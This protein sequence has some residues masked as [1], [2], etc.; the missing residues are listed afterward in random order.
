MF[1]YTICLLAALVVL[2][3]CASPDPVPP[4]PTQTPA[5]AV[6]TADS[7]RVEAI[8]PP[9]ESYVD[10]EILPG[11]SLITYQSEGG[12]Y[13]APLDPAT[14]RLES[15]GILV[16]TGAARLLATF[17]GPEFGIDAHG[18]A[19]YY[20]KPHAGEVQ[21]WRATLDDSGQPQAEP[22]TAGSRFQTQLVSRNPDADTT[23]IA[24]IEGTWQQ[25]TAVWFDEAEPDV[26]Y[27]IDSI[28]NGVIPLR[29]VDGSSLITLSERTGPARGQLSLLDTDTNT[30]WQI[31]DDDG[32]KTDPYGW[33]APEFGGDLLV[34]AIVDNE[35]VAIYRDT[36]GAMW[37]RIA[38]LTPPPEARFDFVA[39]AEPFTVGGR[40]YLS[41]VVKDANSSRQAFSDSEVWLFDI[42]DDPQGRYAERGDSGEPGIA[43]SDPEVFIGTGHVFVYYNVIGGDNAA[44]PYAVRRCR[45]GIM[46]DGTAQQ[47]PSMPPDAQPPA[48]SDACQWI[49]P[50]EADAAVSTAFDPHYV[51]HDPDAAATDG[52]LVFL[53]GT[54]AAPA[55][56]ELFVQEAAAVG[57]HA[58]GLSYVNPRSVNLQICPDDTDPDCHAD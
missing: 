9:G 12:I 35:S 11:G 51:C 53:P 7:D 23:H 16:D 10:P 47:P 31:T 29:W 21:I 20:A 49:D 44:E 33:F 18:W 14:G 2:A 50:A 38:T 24:A 42:N 52:L 4:S 19:L 27:P 30:T 17:N 55:D 25:G 5:A 54:G 48:S 57:L 8:S 26:I 40:S 22:L 45:S 32:D 28:E 58:I 39:S 15:P 6:T 13:L 46:V 37:E 56:Y 3:A 41:L 43:R 36:G 1:R 34:L